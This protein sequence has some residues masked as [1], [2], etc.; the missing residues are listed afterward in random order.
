MA[1]RKDKSPSTT[2]NNLPDIAYELETLAREVG[3]SYYAVKKFLYDY[4][5]FFGEGFGGF[6]TM[7]IIA[8]RGPITMPRLAEYLNCSRQ[9]LQQQATSLIDKGFLKTLENPA[10]KRSKLLALTEK[11]KR[12]F[13]KR[14][15]RYL[16]F[17]ATLEDQFTANE[18]SNATEV[19]S[20]LRDQ[21]QSL[22]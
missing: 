8:R 20:R 2:Q 15:G 9:Y 13:R 18:V 7:A 14:R 5:V 10:H 12:E 22:D 17:Y 16:E 6:R 19:L 11:G 1:P 4:D 3:R 21:L